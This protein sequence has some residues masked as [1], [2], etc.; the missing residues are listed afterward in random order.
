MRHTTTPGFSKA[1]RTQSYDQKSD[2]TNSKTFI[3]P[4]S[5]DVWGAHDLLKLNICTCIFS[6]HS[7]KDIL[8]KNFMRLK[9]TLQEF[10]IFHSPSVC[11][12]GSEISRVICDLY[13]FNAARASS[14]MYPL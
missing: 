3:S 10:S 11:H 1:A 12:R 13:K 5:L 14:P 8:M 9:K 7:I 2:K 6:P 4:N